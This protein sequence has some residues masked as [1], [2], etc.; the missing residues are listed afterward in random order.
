MNGIV[1]NIDPV[2]FRIGYFELR[3]YSIAIILA[4]VVAMVIADH[5]GKRKGLPAD[6]VYS[7]VPVVLIAGLI[8]ARLFHVID[9]WEYY[10]GNLLQV[11][12]LQRGGLA[13]WGGLVGGGVAA[14]VYARIRHI[15][16]GH[17]ADTMVPALLTAQI[18]GRL[19]CIINGD[20]YGGITSLPWGFIYTNP[21]A[22]IPSTLLGVP[23]H[24]YPLY[25]MLGNGV[26]LLAL[27]KLRH[28]LK[29]DGLLFF[30]YLSLYSMW[31]FIL[32]FVRQENT[33][34]WQLQ[35]AQLIAI[36][37]LVITAAAFIYLSR[38]GKTLVPTPSLLL[39]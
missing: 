14:F 29:K 30:G 24:P 10:A 35:Q 33:V 21:D 15:P 9:Q 18:I 26:T 5:E 17:L 32:T 19:G 8:G 7:L 13:I 20:A 6:F 34:I 22:L 2:I 31:R 1:I 12:Q 4:A 11:L 28:S 16:V 38:K 25:E 39:D 3:W 37:T 36:A 27:P 23:T